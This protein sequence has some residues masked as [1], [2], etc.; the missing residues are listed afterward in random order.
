MF[1]FVTLIMSFNPITPILTTNK[2]IKHNYVDQKRNLDIL[3][4]SKEL[5]WVTQEFALNNPNKQP[6]KEHGEA[7]NRWHKAG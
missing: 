5:E 3:L 7:Q 4:T 2:L 1:I 6:S